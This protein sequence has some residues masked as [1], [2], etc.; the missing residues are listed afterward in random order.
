MRTP[1]CERDDYGTDCNL[2]P[3]DVRREALPIVDKNAPS[4]IYGY[5]IV[6]YVANKAYANICIGNI[7]S[8]SGGG[9]GQRLAT[10]TLPHG[11]QIDG[12]Y[13]SMHLYLGRISKTN[14]YLADVAIENVSKSGDAVSITFRI[15]TFQQVTGCIV[16]TKQ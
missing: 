9:I 6:D 15:Q 7:V 16:M 3:Q 8:N 1:T 4:I 2:P 11:Y 14:G 12:Y 13:D 10:L 5:A